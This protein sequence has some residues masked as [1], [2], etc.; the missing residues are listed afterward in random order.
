[1]VRDD[2]LYDTSFANGRFYIEKNINFFLKRQDP[3]GKYGLSIPLFKGSEARSNPMIKFNIIGYEPIDTS[4]AVDII[5][6]LSNTC[7]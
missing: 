2:E 6:K 5:N 3:I 1:M 7:F 4:E